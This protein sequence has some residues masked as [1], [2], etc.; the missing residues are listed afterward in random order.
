MALN[1]EILRRTLAKIE[2]TRGTGVTPTRKVYET[3]RLA[4]SK[5]P[6]E[7]AEST[8]TFDAWR[9]FL[10]GPLSVT[11]TVEGPASFEDI[12]WWLEHGVKGG[13]S[14]SGDAGSPVAYTRDY[15]PSA[16]TDDLAASTMEHGAPDPGCYKTTMVMLPSWSLRGDIDGEAAWMF[17]G[18]LIGKT[19]TKENA[20]TSGINDRTREFIK[21]AGT[22]LYIDEPGGTIGTTQV[23]AKFISF[24]LD[25]NNAVSTKRFMED[26]SGISSVIGRGARQITGQIRL[27]FDS[28]AEKAKFRAGTKRLIRIERDGSVIHTT[29]KNRVRIDIPDAYWLTPSEDAR[30][31]NMTLTFGFRAYTGSAGYPA[32]VEV[33]NGVQTL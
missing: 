21:A 20:F 25:W 13:V 30:E 22:K 11:G 33:V 19:F 15:T 10:Q 23:S 14:A 9:T 3:V 7:F 27:E 4:E 12:A 18:S 28:D 1:E 32:K 2:T 8:G 31:N 26:E 29:V 24:S 16:A 6:L 17:S 5:E